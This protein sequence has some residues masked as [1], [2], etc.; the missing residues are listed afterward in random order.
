MCYIYMLYIYM[1]YIYVIY[2]YVIYM[3]VCYIYYIYIIGYNTTFWSR[4][5]LALPMGRL[6][7]FG[8]RTVVSSCSVGCAA[9]DT[10]EDMS[11]GIC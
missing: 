10:V 6:R 7:T 8:P 2:I 4:Q 1:L 9:S 5:F 11:E 3:C